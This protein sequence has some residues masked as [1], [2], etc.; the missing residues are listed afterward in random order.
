MEKIYNISLLPNQQAISSVANLAH[1]FEE[2]HVNLNNS[3]FKLKQTINESGFMEDQ[4][5]RKWFFA[6]GCDYS[7]NP[8]LFAQAPLNFTCAYLSEIFKHYKIE[9]IS[10]DSSTR[11]IKRAL[12][13]LDAFR[14]DG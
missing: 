14:I 11:A 9:Q 13:R 10:S 12:L 4:D 8:K 5:H 6:H 2:T 3:L 1:E 7:S